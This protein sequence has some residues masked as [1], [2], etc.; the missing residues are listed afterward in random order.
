MH[1]NPTIQTKEIW[2]G[3]LTSW[4]GGGYWGTQPM[5]QKI[6]KKFGGGRDNR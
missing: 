6:R 3:A 4:E 5:K 2:G 1:F